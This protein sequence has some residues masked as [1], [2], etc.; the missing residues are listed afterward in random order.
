MMSR[1]YSEKNQLYN[2]FSLFTNIFTNAP[3]LSL[4]TRKMT[5]HNGM[6]DRVPVG[7]MG[8]CRETA[9]YYLHHAHC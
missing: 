5:R 1:A 6:T 9:Q 3:G 7:L 2:I 4:V 8:L